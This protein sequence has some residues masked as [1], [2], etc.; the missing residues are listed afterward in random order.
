MPVFT[1]GGNGRSPLDFSKMED[2]SVSPSKLVDSQSLIHSAQ[3]WDLCSKYL[4][5]QEYQPL[6]RS[7]LGRSWV[8]QVAALLH[9]IS[10]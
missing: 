9:K 6:L 10:A 3:S 8:Q 2:V 1:T 4:G 7:V 5:N